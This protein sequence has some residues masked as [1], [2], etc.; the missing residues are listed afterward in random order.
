MRNRIM[1]ALVALAAMLG[2]GLGVASPAQAAFSD[3]PDHYFCIWVGPNGGATG[4][5]FQYHYNTFVDSYHNGIR[6]PSGVANRGTSFY[7]RTHAAVIIFDANN[8]DVAQ[9]NR[10]MQNNQYANA[11]GSD[12][13]DRVSSIQLWNASPLKC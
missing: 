12:W 6:L 8:C 3:C 7:N 2:L 10:E 9:W 1:A 4:T 13:Y 5:R 11:V